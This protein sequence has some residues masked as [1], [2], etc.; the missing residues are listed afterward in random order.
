[1]FPQCSIPVCSRFQFYLNFSLCFCGISEVKKEY[2][3]I[4]NLYIHRIF[5][6]L[7]WRILLTLVA[8]TPVNHVPS[9]SWTSFPTSEPASP[10]FP[11]ETHCL[12][13]P[14]PQ[15]SSLWYSF[16]LLGL[17][18]PVLVYMNQVI[19]CSFSSCPV[20]D[21]FLPWRKLHFGALPFSHYLVNHLM[22]SLGLLKLY[23][24]LHQAPVHVSVETPH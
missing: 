9:F 14:T 16:A 7:M 20:C 5:F 10:P 6:S 8:P 1:M 17:Y 4:N 2:L 11:A 22:S 24:L 21:S 15:W 23:L 12:M 13:N 3:T 19:H 18:V